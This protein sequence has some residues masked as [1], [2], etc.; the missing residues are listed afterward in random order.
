MMTK[1]DMVYLVSS[2]GR[3]SGD[4][5]NLKVFISLVDAHAF[6]DKVQELWNKDECTNI[7]SIDSFLLE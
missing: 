7:I 1:G 3:H 6:A 5:E 4:V 2:Y